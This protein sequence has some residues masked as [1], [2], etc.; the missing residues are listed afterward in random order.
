MRQTSIFDDYSHAMT[1]EQIRRLDENN[2]LNSRRN[3]RKIP[4]IGAAGGVDI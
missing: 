4:S 1:H 2:N 3:G